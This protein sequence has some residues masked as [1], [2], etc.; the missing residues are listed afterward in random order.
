MNL[1]PEQSNLT[2]LII[3]KKFKNYILGPSIFNHFGPKACR[4]GN[5]Q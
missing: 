1:K 2:G 3:L 5:L 4:K